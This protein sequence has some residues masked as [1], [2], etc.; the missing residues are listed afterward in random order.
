MHAYKCSIYASVSVCV[1]VCGEGLREGVG[2]EGSS[3]NYTNLLCP[4]NCI[5]GRTQKILKLNDNWDTPKKLLRVK[6][7][8]ISI[9]KRAQFLGLI[10]PIVA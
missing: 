10:G 2:W 6:K 3:V 8:G 5:T 7:L 9:M 1:C 4:L